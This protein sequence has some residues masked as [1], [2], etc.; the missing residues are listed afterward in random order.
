MTQVHE[1]KCWPESFA[2][3][4]HERKTFELRKDDR[5]FQVGDYLLLRE[6]N[7]GPE[8]FTGATKLVSVTHILR[9]GDAFGTM[10]MDKDVVIMSIY[11]LDEQDAMKPRAPQ[12]AKEEA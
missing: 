2:D 12:P 4:G 3:I 11:V 1:L 7:P 10:L 8:E 5:G 6:Y 9:E